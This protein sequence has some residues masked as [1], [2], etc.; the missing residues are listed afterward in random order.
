MPNLVK[1][2]MFKLTKKK[3][4][5]IE[6]IVLLVLQT[7][8]AWFVKS[9]SNLSAGVYFNQG[10]YGFQLALFFLLAAAA[11]IITSEFEYGT[12][13]NLFYQ[14]HNR[15]Q[16]LASKWITMLCYALFLYILV[17]LSSLLLKLI[18]FPSLNLTATTGFNGSNLIV[19]FLEFHSAQ[20]V[21]NL[22]LISLVMLV[23]NLFTNSTIAVSVGI[24]GY[25]VALLA[26]SSVESL[27]NR[28]EWLKWSP[29]TMLN[30]PVLVNEGVA[31]LN[32]LTSSQMLTGNLVYMGIFLLLGY[33]AFNRRNV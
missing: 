7:F 28:W 32:K 20:L 26:S 9:N 2:E 1:Q 15:G 25:F 29:L 12:I 6:I 31:H 13:K 24:I 18:L 22:L 16:V 27:I 17:V 11:S 5:W 3:S 19:H 10:F 14:K 30:Y 21:I 23:A 4:T 33:V 8:I